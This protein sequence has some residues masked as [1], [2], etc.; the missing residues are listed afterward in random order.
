VLDSLKKNPN[1]TF[2]QLKDMYSLA[3]EQEILE[4]IKEYNYESRARDIIDSRL[5]EKEMTEGLL[6]SLDTL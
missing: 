1:L 2:A 4:G 6:G 3:D 5:Y